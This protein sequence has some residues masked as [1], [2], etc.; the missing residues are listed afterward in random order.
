MAG[1]ALH[2]GAPP[3]GFSQRRLTFTEKRPYPGVQGP[4]HY[5]VSSPD[6]EHIAFLMK[7]VQGDAQLFL[8]SP[9]GKRSKYRN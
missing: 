1:D 8:I 7:D 3:K 6:G 5:M 4:R 9:R 2:M